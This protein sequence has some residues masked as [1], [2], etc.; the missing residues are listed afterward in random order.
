[1]PHNNVKK[2]RKKCNVS[3]ISGK[4]LT[5]ASQQ[6][7]C[8][9]EIE[10]LSEERDK[11]CYPSSMYTCMYV[12][13]YTAYM[14]N[15]HHIVP[16]IYLCM[17]PL[18]IIQLFRYTLSMLLFKSP[19]HIPLSKMALGGS[20]TFAVCKSFIPASRPLVPDSNH[21]YSSSQGQTKPHCCH[22]QLNLLKP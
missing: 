17:L 10:H 6:Q 22:H 2:F 8:Q 7:T 15:A 19:Y 3:N 1:M 9:R 16:M 13:I 11:N 5:E 20:C 21:A 12:C 18:F 4:W 14:H